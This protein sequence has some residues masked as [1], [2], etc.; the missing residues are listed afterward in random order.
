MPRIGVEPRCSTNY[1]AAELDSFSSSFFRRNCLCRFWI[2][3]CVTF[4]SSSIFFTHIIL[5][6]SCSCRNVGLEAA[7]QDAVETRANVPMA[8]LPA[9]MGFADIPRMKPMPTPLAIPLNRL[10]RAQ[11]TS[12]I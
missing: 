11:G 8:Q 2:A 9:T 10:L 5:S 3:L 7:H 1:F 12:P 6:S 4:W